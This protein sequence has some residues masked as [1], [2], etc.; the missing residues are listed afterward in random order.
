MK[1][2]M[3]YTPALQAKLS[4]YALISVLFLGACSDPATVGLELAPQNNQIGV[5][6]KEFT[7]DAQVVLLDSFNT[8]N[9]GV[10]C[11]NFLYQI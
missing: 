8:T 2:F 3:E 9:S 11:S 6:Y 4:I 5:F 7:L 10:L 1:S